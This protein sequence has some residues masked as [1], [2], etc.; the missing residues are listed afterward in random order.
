M[1]KALEML[2]K[3]VVDK[4]TGARGVVTSV[5]FDLYGCCQ[6]L[7]NPG[8]DDAGKIREQNWFDYARITVVDTV[9]VM[10]QPSFDWIG[11]TS[12]GPNDL[13]LNGKV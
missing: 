6:L 13:P 4:V 11:T 3:R 5:S 9:P 12:K 2:G 8:V 7:V 10:D 1:E